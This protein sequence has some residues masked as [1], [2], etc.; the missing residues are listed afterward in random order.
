MR[1]RKRR[2]K[3]IVIGITADYDPAEKIPV[4]AADEGSLYL[5]DRY[6]RVIADLGA[7]PLI[8]PIVAKP[9]LMEKM[10]DLVDGVMVSGGAFDIHPHYYGETPRPELGAV[11]ENRT[12]FEL[13]LLRRAFRRDLPVL[14]ICGGMQAIN[15]ACGG[16]LFQDL[17]AQRPESLPH[18]QS[19]PRTQPSHS[20][21]VIPGTLL[22]QV[23]GQK[24]RALELQVNST[25]HQAVKRLGRGL[26]MNARAEDGVIEA[27]SGFRQSFVLGVQWHP[28]LLV[29]DFPAQVRIF[30]AFLAA[31][32]TA[33]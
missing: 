13:E 27:V 5:K 15:V 9:K 20:V 18:Q 10:L 28:E 32:A 14:G 26:V 21:T 7:A 33:T 8:L 29:P 19:L 1:P 25:H 11:R 30:R 3:T 24:K 23:L 31:A 16:A 4:R 6:Y 2:L 22:A 12:E 17:A